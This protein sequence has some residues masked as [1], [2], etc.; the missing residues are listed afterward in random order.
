[1]R[2]NKRGEWIPRSRATDAEATP[3]NPLCT[4]EKPRR[5]KKKLL[6]D[7]CKN[8]GGMGWLLEEPAADPATAHN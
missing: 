5:R 2:K 1:M 7:T 8:C 3:A 4:G 6:R